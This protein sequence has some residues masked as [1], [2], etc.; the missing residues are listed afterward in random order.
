[1]ALLRRDHWFSVLRYVKTTRLFPLRLVCKAACLAAQDLLNEREFY[2]SLTRCDLQ[3]FSQMRWIRF[4]DIGDNTSLIDALRTWP[5][6]GLALE[7]NSNL[8]G[9]TALTTVQ[10]LRCIA[11]NYPHPD[12]LSLC[13]IFPNVKRLISD[14]RYGWHRDIPLNTICSLTSLTSFKTRMDIEYD[15]RLSCISANWKTLSSLTGLQCL[16]ISP[17]LFCHLGSLLDLEISDLYMGQS[18]TSLSLLS[19]LTKLE[20]KG[21]MTTSFIS[22]LPKTL[23]TLTLSYEDPDD[24]DSPYTKNVVISLPLLTSLTILNYSRVTLSMSRLSRLNIYG[25]STIPDLPSSL[26]VLTISVADDIDHHAELDWRHLPLETLTTNYLPKILF[27]PGHILRTLRVNYCETEEYPSADTLIILDVSPSCP[28]RDAFANTKCRY[29]SFNAGAVL[30]RYLESGFVTF[31]F[32]P[33]NVPIHF[34]YLAP[35]P[36]SVPIGVRHLRTR[37][38]PSNLRAL[39]VGG[40]ESITLLPCLRHKKLIADCTSCPSPLSPDEV[41]GV[42]L[43]Q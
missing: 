39:L 2:I 37:V 11:Y 20:V 29:F 31:P 35:F 27:P 43:C 38:I 8:H 12:P 6:T 34:E 33:P 1:M 19:S 17:S 16:S 13:S 18:S 40:L 42:L 15:K 5:L 22:S 21:D 28:I 26:K 30:P 9:V 32:A 23:Y 14:N 7:F 41:S 24:D 25:I 3:Y 4:F 36:V 10:T